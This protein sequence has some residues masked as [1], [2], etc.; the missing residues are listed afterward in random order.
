VC[1]DDEKNSEEDERGRVIQEVDCR[2]GGMGDRRGGWREVNQKRRIKGISFFLGVLLRTQERR[3][4]A[5]VS[6]GSDRHLPLFSGNG[7][8]EGGIRL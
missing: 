3:W 7:C 4:F 1:L 6:G 8:W 2:S 5:Y